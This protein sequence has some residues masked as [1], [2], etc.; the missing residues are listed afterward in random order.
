MHRALQLVPIGA[1]LVPAMA[2]AQPSPI[3]GGGNADC[4]TLV[5]RDLFYTTQGN[6]QWLAGYVSG[7]AA[8]SESLARSQGSRSS[9]A[10][11]LDAYEVDDL[12]QMAETYCRANPDHYLYQAGN[13]IITRLS[14]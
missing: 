5:E 7:A 6:M 2:M 11:R 9:F 12:I 4:E 14:R 8:L 10:T 13:S 1:L 3:I